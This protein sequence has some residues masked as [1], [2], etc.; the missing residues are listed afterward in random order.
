MFETKLIVNGTAVDATSTRVF[1]R[2]SAMGDGVATISAAADHTDAHTA[3]TAAAAAFPAWS[4]SPDSTRASVLNTAADILLSRSDD[5]CAAM[6]RET[7]ATARWARFNC[8]VAAGML[9]HAAKMATFQRQM[10]RTGYDADVESVL[11][12]QPV[13]V[14]LGI[15]PW[16]APIVLATRALAVP[17]A[18]GN[19][20]VLKASDRCPKTH[21]LVVE[22]LIE[23]GIPAGVV[24]LVTHAPDSA[25]DIVEALVAHPAIRR[26]NFTGSTRV[27]RNIAVTCAQHLKPVVLELSGKAALIVLEDAD[28]ARAVRAA[29]HGAFF[30][31]GQVC[32]STE[33][34]VVNHR[35]ADEFVD[36]LVHEVKSVR[37]GT[38]DSE[39]TQFGPL[40]S[41]DAALRVQRLV[42]DAVDKGA[43]LLAGGTVTKSTMAPSIL[44]NVNASMRI[45]RE[46]SFGPVASIVRVG[47]EDEAVTV[48]NDTEYGLTAAVHSRDIDRA[49]HVARQLDCGVCQINGSTVYDDA[50]MPFGGMKA[51]GYGK[52][53]GEES[54]TE[55]TELRW[56]AVH[57]SDRSM[58]L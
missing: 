48:A 19:T 10:T 34:I 58:H 12:R 2:E 22:A 27:G 42:E 56:V 45:Y 21:S 36:A 35:V 49:M 40:I 51:S 24:N 20:T 9:R 11:I 15:A 50:N 4:Q 52:L 57:R 16:N 7:G 41:A 5:V 54:I 30:N 46:E 14:V 43:T 6:A 17:L 25:T 3:A 26:V 38:P 28:I 55:F 44:D 53:S 32:L 33:R 13:G 8:R 31:Q 18:V 37:V 29:L 39:D 1:E 23:A 47:S